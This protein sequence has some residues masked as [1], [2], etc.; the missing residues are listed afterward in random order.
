MV[1]SM[2]ASILLVAI[3]VFT[4]GVS[5]QGSTNNRLQ[6]T[7]DQAVKLGLENSK[8]LHASSMKVEQADARESEARTNR[9][10]SLKLNGAY[11][12]LS[13][14]PPATIL[15]PLGPTP[16]AFTLFPTILDNYSTRVT[17]QQALFTGFKI[18]NSAQAAEYSTRAAEQDY[19]GDKSTL[20]FNIK[21]AYWNLFKATEIK[22]VVDENVG[23]VKGH[24]ND[25]QTWM[26]Q[27]LSTNNEVLRVQV[28]L[29]NAQLAQID[30]NNNVQL[31]TIALDNVMGI[32]LTNQIEILSAPEQS[33]DSSGNIA[34][35]LGPVDSYVKR[36]N[37][38]RPELRAMDYRVK[39][40]ESSVSAAKG[41]WL[42]QIY[43]TGNYNYARPNSRIFPAVDAF[44]D[45][46]D[47]T[48][49]A[50]WDI[51]NWGATADQT[52]QAQAQLSQAQDVYAQVR[53]N[54]S[55]DVTQSY[56]SVQQ[57][58]QRISV[59]A[60]SVKQAEENYRVTNEKFKNGLA[61]NTDLLD[62]EVAQL[63]AKTNYTQ[64]LVDYEVALAR[65]SKAT[66][67]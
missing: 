66:G 60:T 51:W 5:A 56:L 61:L 58:A 39:A 64:A 53:D 28:Q 47:L 9:L 19:A 15:V 27:G 37:E 1:R 35:S 65:L 48:V 10:P 18:E 21:N 16:T 20:I 2:R 50:S 29:S 62:A 25:V 63:Q 17:L 14:I 22:K 46:W 26:N 36:A 43:L 59:A 40:G 6:L 55:L 41:A 24:L 13:D 8:S 3:I 31:A 23:Q 7:V 32:P 11:T 33:K 38:T 49:S 34:A 44:K 45:T 54:I 57:S 30:A 52:T 12:R 42:P 67:E 4:A